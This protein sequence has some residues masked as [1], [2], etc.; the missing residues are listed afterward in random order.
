MVSRISV[1]YMAFFGK[2]AKATK[3]TEL[4]QFARAGAGVKL[5]PKVI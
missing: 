2:G 3:R 4:L 1:A 5:S